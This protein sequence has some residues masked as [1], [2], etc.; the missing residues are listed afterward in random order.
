MLPEHLPDSESLEELYARNGFLRRMKVFSLLRMD[1]LKAL[2]VV[3]ESNLGLNLSELLNG[4]TIIVNDPDGL[5][6]DILSNA[7]NHLVSVYDTPVVPLLVYPL[8]YLEE[9]KISYE[10][11][12]Q[13]L[14]M[15]MQHGMD[16]IYFMQQQLKTK[17][18]FILKY[19]IRKYIK[20]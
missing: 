16:F 2:L 18:R 10:K 5:T 12:Y 11:K 7:L 1:K 8:T 19:L 4:I 6:W 15:D 9:R 14:I 13:M 17:I 3:N 20:K